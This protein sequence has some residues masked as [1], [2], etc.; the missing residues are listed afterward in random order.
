M[1]VH[2]RGVWDMLSHG[3]LEG[4]GSAYLRE[5]LLV[6]ARADDERYQLP[7]LKPAQRELRALTQEVKHL[8]Q[9][10]TTAQTGLTFSFNLKHTDGVLWREVP[11]L[12]GWE[13]VSS[14]SQRADH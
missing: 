12:A 11:E 6:P 2:S 7:F 13:C 4:K 1:D 10:S 3:L 9:G 8:I 5:P 14:L